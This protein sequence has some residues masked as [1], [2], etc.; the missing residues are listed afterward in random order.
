MCK[1]VLKNNLP[2]LVTRNSESNVNGATPTSVVSGVAVEAVDAGR[3]ENQEIHS[4]SPGYSTKM[5]LR[6]SK[7]LF[8]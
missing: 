8:R 3:R 6:L 2:S 1:Y 5:Y 7:Q 4:L